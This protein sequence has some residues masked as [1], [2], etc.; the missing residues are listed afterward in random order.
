MLADFSQS[1]VSLLPPIVALGMA[2]IS[3]RVL[4]SLGLGILLGAILL[5]DF[6]LTN[7]AN[8]VF[9]AVSGLFWEEGGINA[10]NMSILAFLILLGMTTA[11]LTLSGG[12]AAFAE[13][14]QKHIRS[15]RGAK[16]LAA[17]LVYSFLWMTIST[18]WQWVQF[19]VLLPTASIFPV[20]SWLIFSTPL[21]RLCASLCRHQAGGRI[22]SLLSAVFSFHTVSLNTPRWAHL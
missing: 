17:F 9:T 18:A 8:Y 21:L 11:L 6:S 13:W 5:N 16:L 10:G 22:S 15:K 12:T 1:A 19:R 14:A 3:R 2:I 7:T 20:Q 4:L